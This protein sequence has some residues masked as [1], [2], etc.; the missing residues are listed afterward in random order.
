MFMGYCYDFIAPN[1][2]GVVC[3]CSCCVRVVTTFGIDVILYHMYDC[4]VIRSL[5]RVLI[6]V[7][8]L[9]F[10]LTSLT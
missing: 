3:L 2:H 8:I 6:V 4:A 1:P 10:S 9:P 5:L 7:V